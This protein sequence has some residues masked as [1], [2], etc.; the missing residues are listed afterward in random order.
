VTWECLVLELVL[1]VLRRE[2]MCVF[3]DHRLNWG[4]NTSES[5]VQNSGVMIHSM[6]WS[7]SLISDLSLDLPEYLLHCSTGQLGSFFF[8]PASS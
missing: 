3:A 7:F 6:S 5:I 4:S 8:R 2:F 1:G